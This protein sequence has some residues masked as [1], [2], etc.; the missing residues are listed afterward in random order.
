MP[1]YDFI[2]FGFVGLLY[3]MEGVHT[4]GETFKLFPYSY[5]LKI[6]KIKLVAYSSQGSHTGQ[7]AYAT[8]WQIAV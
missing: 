3:S 4:S 1:Q 7:Q 6:L 5:I 2:I 8:D